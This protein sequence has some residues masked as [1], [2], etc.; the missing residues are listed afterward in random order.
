[1]GYDVYSDTIIDV[2]K[3]GI[4]DPLTVKKQVIAFSTELAI[5]FTRIDD[6]IKCNKK[7]PG[8]K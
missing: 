5:T 6:I 3:A 2:I 7:S 1:M 4:I 8:G